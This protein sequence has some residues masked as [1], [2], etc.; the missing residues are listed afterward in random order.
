M[1]LKICSGRSQV[2][3]LA[4]RLL[5]PVFT[6]G[7]LPCFHD[8]QDIFRTKCLAD[9]NQRDF[10]GFASNRLS[11]RLNSLANILQGLVLL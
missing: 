1:K 10:A 5:D 4:R 6:K 8:R 7:Y 9:G 11:S 3:P 2:G